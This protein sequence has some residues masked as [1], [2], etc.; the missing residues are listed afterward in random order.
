MKIVVI[1]RGGHSKVIADMIL[2]DQENDI[3]GYLD[4]KYDNVGLFENIY[5]GPISSATQ[6]VEHFYDLKFVIAIGD[7]KV[8]QSIVQKLNLPDET[9]LSVIHKSAV[10]SLS[11]K[12]DIGTVVMPHTVINADT[13]IGVHSI[14]NTGSVIE[15]DCII[16]DYSHICPGTTLTG[17]VQIG[18]GGYIGAGAT[19]IPNIKVGDWAIVG[20]GATVITDIPAH[21]TAVG[22]PAKIKKVDPMRVEVN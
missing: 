12:I 5:C 13:R 1:G 3:V 11:A 9:Y 19:I 21:C 7:N 4:D 20:A 2:S 22:I 10:I 8:R 18:E 6:L 15:H 17:T 14:I 16:G